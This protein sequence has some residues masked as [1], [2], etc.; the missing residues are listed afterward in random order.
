MAFMSDCISKEASLNMSTVILFLLMCQSGMSQPNPPLRIQMPQADYG[1]FIVPDFP[2]QS[3]AAA[4]AYEEREFVRRVDGLLR[5]LGDFA[6]SYRTGVVDLK[7]AKAV[8]KA[9]HELEKSEWFKE[10]I[11]K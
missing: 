10:D 2:D 9:L 7:K 1:R 4:A 8:R 3:P 11:R 6:A 5:A